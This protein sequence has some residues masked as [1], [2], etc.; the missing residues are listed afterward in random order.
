MTETIKAIGGETRYDGHAYRIWFDNRDW[1]QYSVHADNPAKQWMIR[2]DFSLYGG[3]CVSYT[4]TEIPGLIFPECTREEAERAMLGMLSAGT[5]EC[6]HAYG[7]PVHGK[8]K[9]V[10]CGHESRE[11]FGRPIK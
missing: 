8:A 11:L 3:R 10:K 7:I 6:Q 9:C 5:V 4:D 2:K 1:I